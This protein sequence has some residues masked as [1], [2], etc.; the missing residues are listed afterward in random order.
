M[1]AQIPEQAE[2]VFKEVDFI[3]Q[4]NARIAAI[5]RPAIHLIEYAE[6]FPKEHSSRT[7]D[8][9][10]RAAVV[11]LHAALEDFLRYIGSKYIPSASEDVLNKIS[12]I[13]SSD[14]VRPEKF[15]LGKL[16][17]HRDKTVD[18]LIAKSVEAHLDKRSFSNP[19]DISQLLESA[20]IPTSEVERLYPSLSELMARRHNIVHKGDLKPTANKHRER[21]PKPIDARKVREWYET[22]MQ[23]TSAVAAYKLG[24][25]V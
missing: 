12:V 5:L 24:A 13:G 10:L 8:D 21:E 23:F 11:F 4:Y 18:Q 17:K 9:I 19:A 20:G 22:I 1:A 7:K 14:V 3:N 25:G 15:F 6:T 16:A 2:R